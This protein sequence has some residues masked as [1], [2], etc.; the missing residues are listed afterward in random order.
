M[1]GMF[2]SVYMPQWQQ[3]FI[4]FFRGAGLEEYAEKISAYDF[5]GYINGPMFALYGEDDFAAGAGPF[6]I[7]LN[8]PHF[9]KITDMMRDT[10]LKDAFLIGLSE[11]YFDLL[12]PNQRKDG[13]YRLI[14]EGL[15]NRF[16]D[17]EVKKDNK[18]RLIL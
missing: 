7:W 18:R 11:M 12:A 9:S 4:R 15:A 10:R 1:G 17:N 16:P 13:W 8:K 5:S 14:A 6:E 3:C 2:Q